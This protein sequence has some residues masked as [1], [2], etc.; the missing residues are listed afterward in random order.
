MHKADIIISG[1]GMV[2]LSLGLALAQGGFRVAVADPQPMTAQ[3]FGRP[4]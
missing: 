4:V 3:L 2:G 1:G